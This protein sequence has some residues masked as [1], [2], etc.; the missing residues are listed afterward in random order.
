M[1]L[2]IIVLRSKPIEMTEPSPGTYVFNLG[3]NIA[4]I[5]E[6]K[7]QGPKGTKIQLRFGEILKNDGQMMAKYRPKTYEKLGLPTPSI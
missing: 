7:V 5:A 1:L 4:G 6:L 2:Y 3:K